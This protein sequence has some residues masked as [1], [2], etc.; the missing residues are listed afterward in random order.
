MVIKYEIEHYVYP[1]GDSKITEST[2]NELELTDLVADMTYSIR[3]RA[4]TPVGVT[5]WTSITEPVTTL[6]EDSGV[7]GPSIIANEDDNEPITLSC[8]NSRYGCYRLSGCPPTFFMIASTQQCFKV[9]DEEKRSWSDSKKKC[10]EEGLQ[11]AHPYDAIALQN[12]MIERYNFNAWVWL[13]ARGDGSNLI[14]ERNGKAIQNGDV[15]WWPGKP[16]SNTG[17]DRCLYMLSHSSHRSS[18]PGKPF[19]SN[20]CSTPR[21]TLC[22]LVMD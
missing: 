20:T 12:Y 21:I 5:A 11:L 1:A 8:P 15:L 18:N 13:G 22:E 16:G 17:T 2:S 19:S 3:C 9:M 10:E 7:G 4:V 14:W 6:P